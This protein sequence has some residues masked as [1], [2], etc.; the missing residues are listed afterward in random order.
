MS[1]A[2]AERKVWRVIDLIHWAEEYFATHGFE[3]PRREIEWLLRDLLNCSRID[4]Y[5]RF[6]EPLDKSQLDTLRSWVKRRL[7]RE[8]LQYITGTAEFYGLKFTVNPSVLIPRPETERVVDVVIHAAG[9][10]ENPRILDVGTGSG[11]I[12]LAVAHEL[13]QARITALDIS[14]EALEVARLNAQQLKITN[15]RFLQVDFLKSPVDGPFDIVVS[16]PPYVTVDEMGALM[17]D[18]VDFEPHLALTDYNDGFSFYRRLSEVAP[19]LVR[20]G[21]YLVLEVGLGDHPRERRRSCLKESAF[22]NRN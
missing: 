7:K 3:Y 5:L 15:V 13:P 22:P 2:R 6:E 21:G 1:P 16:N 19:E 4:L 17:K 12:A 20:D 11:C 8:P 18:V 10:Q 9:N 14:A